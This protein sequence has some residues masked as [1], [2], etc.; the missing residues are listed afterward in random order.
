MMLM[1]M[2]MIAGSPLMNTGKLV[3]KLATGPSGTD[4]PD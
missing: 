1:L 2:L 4:W 3:K